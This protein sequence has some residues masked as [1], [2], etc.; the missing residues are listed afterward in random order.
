MLFEGTILPVCAERAVR[1]A[2]S[3]FSHSIINGQ[4]QQQGVQVCGAITAA[5]YNFMKKRAST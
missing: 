1:T 4:L 5:D 3:Q 2:V